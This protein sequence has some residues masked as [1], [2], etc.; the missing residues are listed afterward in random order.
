MQ[1]PILTQT[2]YETGETAVTSSGQG[3]EIRQSSE[4]PDF[5]FGAQKKWKRK[6]KKRKKEKQSK[7]WLQIWVYIPEFSHQCFPE[8]DFGTLNK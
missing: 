4:T 6:K 1:P 3:R 5:S 7:L 8:R 2:G